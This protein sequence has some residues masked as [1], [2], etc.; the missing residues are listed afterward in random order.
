MT[1]NELWDLVVSDIY[2][3]AAGTVPMTTVLASLAEATDSDKAF[4]GWYD[5][6]IRTGR[7]EHA[8]NADH[9]L[10]V[11]YNQRLCA[12]NVWF[13]EAQYFQA[14]GLVW[15][16]ARITS[17]K[18]VACSDFCTQFVAPQAIVHT[19]HVVI[20]VEGARVSYVMLTRGPT[21]P[22]YAAAQ[23]ELCRSFAL[24][25]RRALD[26]QHAFGRLRLIQAGLAGVIDEAALGVAIVEPPATPVHAGRSFERMLAKLGAQ[27]PHDVELRRNG[28]NSA[29]RCKIPKALAD[30]IAKHDLRFTANL[31]LARPDCERPLLAELRPF[32]IDGGGEKS[33][34]ALA[35]IIHDPDQQIRIDEDALR[36]AYQTTASEAR[37]CSL[38]AGGERLEDVAAQL[39]ITPHTARTHLKR[40]FEKTGATRQAELMKV[41]L[42][43]ARRRRPSGYSGP[44]Q[45]G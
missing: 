26:I 8:V 23:H 6:A 4:A 31:A 11:T 14:E 19:L 33:R 44:P 29:I 37:I 9:G 21:D 41:V 16:G 17:G 30:A 39:G 3:A 45:S 27:A 35:V 36:T 12:E 43:T 2:R 5:L 24:H 28:T 32:A 18:V 22:E 42:S 13:R 40:I 20:A 25:A 10:V 1:R 15:D 34:R 38:L 7:I